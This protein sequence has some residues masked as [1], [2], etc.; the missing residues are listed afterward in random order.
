MERQPPEPLFRL[1]ASTLSALAD[2]CVGLGED[3]VDALREAGRRAG[4]RIYDA[5]GVLPE[6]L[7][8]EEFWR[9]LDATLGELELGSVSYEPVGEGLGAV[10]WRRLPEA[11]V[12]GAGPRSTHGCPLATGILGGLLSRAAAAPVAVLEVGCAADGSE[13]CWF[14][15]GN[16]ARLREVHQRLSE[17]TPVGAA[18]GR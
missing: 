12:E 4:L 14:L 16:E 11:G 3:G 7:E 8:P 18:L 15:V 6:T 2:R 13:A 5:L 17:G 1:P 9:T 10:S